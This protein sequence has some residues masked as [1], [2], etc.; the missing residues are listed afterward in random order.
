VRPEETISGRGKITKMGKTSVVGTGPAGA[1]VW[2]SANWGGV[3]TPIELQ[4]KERTSA[5]A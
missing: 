3:Y 2:S 5:E 4:R 1:L